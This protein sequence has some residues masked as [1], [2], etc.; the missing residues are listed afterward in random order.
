MPFHAFG[1]LFEYIIFLNIYNI[2][3][4]RNFFH[5]TFAEKS[6]TFHQNRSA[7]KNELK[8]YLSEANHFFHP[9]FITAFCLTS[10][11]TNYF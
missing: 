8:L 1:F 10:L 7:F 5:Y 3:S 6:R 11:Y 2:F 9:L 4:R